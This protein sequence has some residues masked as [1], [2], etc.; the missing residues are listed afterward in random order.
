MFQRGLRAILEGCS[1]VLNGGFRAWVEGFS[2][3]I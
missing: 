1:G 3:H 2:S